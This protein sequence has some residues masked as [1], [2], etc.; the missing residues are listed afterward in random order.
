M[1]LDSTSL[2][3]LKL[4][5]K[6][7]MNPYIKREKRLKFKH[8]TEWINTNHNICNQYIIKLIKIA[9]NDKVP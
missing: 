2:D 9:E 1:L 3:Y 8:F 4:P 7:C 5:E 6:R